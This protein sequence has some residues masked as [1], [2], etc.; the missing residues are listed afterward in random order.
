MTGGFVGLLSLRT[1]SFGILSEQ[2]EEGD[3]VDL[4]G[5][6]QGTGPETITIGLVCEITERDT[7]IISALF[8]VIFL[9]VTRKL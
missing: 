4:E 7:S 3:F 1:Y 6:R 2:M 5:I 9:A 8:E